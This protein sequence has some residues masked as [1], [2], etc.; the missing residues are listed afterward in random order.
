MK[1]EDLQTKQNAPCS[2]A[3]QL[4]VSNTTTYEFFSQ[5]YKNFQTFIEKLAT[6]HPEIS[7]LSAF[8]NI[9]PLEDFRMLILPKLMD[10]L[11]FHGDKE[12]S[13][14]NQECER[15]I[16]QFCLDHELDVDSLGV[17]AD[18]RDK[19]I[20]YSILFCVLLSED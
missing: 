11:I 2:I 17:S 16:L 13:K 7:K 10:A 19:I 12:E 9:L 1:E 5:K 18:A 6:F 8:I 3:T 14:R 20:R 4:A 15:V